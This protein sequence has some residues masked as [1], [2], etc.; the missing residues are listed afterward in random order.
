MK[1]SGFAVA[2]VTLLS[3]SVQ[4]SP[5]HELQSKLVLNLTRF[6][7]GKTAIVRSMDSQRASDLSAL[8]AFQKADTCID[9]LSKNLPTLPRNSELAKYCPSP[10]ALQYNL[11][12]NLLE[13]TVV[14]G[15]PGYILDSAVLQAQCINAQGVEKKKLAS[16]P[17]KNYYGD[18]DKNGSCSQTKKAIR[19]ASNRLHPIMIT[20]NSSSQSLTADKLVDSQKKDLPLEVPAGHAPDLKGPVPAKETGGDAT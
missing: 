12:I 18:H 2:G 13:A 7:H 5:A 20:G 3:F 17:I 19:E 1:Y 16:V 14:D 9:G 11:V 15:Q 4:S 6:I 10:L 8:A